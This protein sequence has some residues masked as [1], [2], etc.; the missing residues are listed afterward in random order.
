MSYSNRHYQPTDKA[1]N[2]RLL[3]FSSFNQMISNGPH[4]FT[5]PLEEW[6]KNP[7]IVISSGFLCRDKTVNSMRWKGWGTMELTLFLYSFT[8]SHFVTHDRSS[9]DRV[10]SD[11]LFS[12]NVTHARTHAWLLTMHPH[13]FTLNCSLY[14]RGLI[15]CFSSA[16]ESNLGQAL[17]NVSARQGLARDVLLSSKC[18]QG[19]LFHY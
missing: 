2:S 13:L 17:H 14:S 11:V 18:I 10:K 1:G 15:T 8:Q 3:A 6:V 4:S 19:H 5:I 12:S 9:W 16:C 7:A